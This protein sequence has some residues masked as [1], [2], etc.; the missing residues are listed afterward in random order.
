[1]SAKFMPLAEVILS[2]EARLNTVRLLIRSFEST[3][4]TGQNDALIL[5]Y[6]SE[7][8]ELRSVLFQLEA[9]TFGYQAEN[10]ADQNDTY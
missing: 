5:K 6:H 8:V 4:G 9:H 7:A 10:K 1:M 2:V 3:N